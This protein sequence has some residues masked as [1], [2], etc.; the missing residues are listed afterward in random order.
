MIVSLTSYPARMETIH[1]CLDSIYAQSMQPDKVVLWLA[2]EQFPNREKDLPDSLL[3]DLDAGKIE[4]FWC[5]DLG[6]HKK[7]FYTMQ[8]KKQ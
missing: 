5:D 2:E 7:Y 8:W 1:Q 6:S 3:E 4:V